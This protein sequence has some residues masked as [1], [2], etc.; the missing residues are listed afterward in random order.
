[1]A[2]ALAVSGRPVR[3]PDPEAEVPGVGKPAAPPEPASADQRG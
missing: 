1:M 2:D 3:A